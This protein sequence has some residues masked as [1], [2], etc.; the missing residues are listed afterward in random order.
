[1]ARNKRIGRL[2]VIT[3]TVLQQRYPAH[4]LA[5]LAIQGGADTIQ[6][7]SKS[8]DFRAMFAEASL[9]REVC[10]RTGVLFIVNDRVDLC[11]AVDADGVHLGSNDMPVE[12]ARRI[13]G[14]NRI[15]GG[16][17]RDVEGLHVAELQGADYVG[18]GPI[19]A[20]KSKLVNHHP[21]GIAGIE[22]VVRAARIPI[23]AIAGITMEN[24]RS[25]VGAGAHGVAV[26]GAVCSAA[27]VVGATA[28]L[29][30]AMDASQ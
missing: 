13:I 6:Y 29:L 1:M 4:Q 5:E 20:T 17:V 30:D 12:V 14:S 8:L 9:V 28:S 16:T 2:H 25:I 19:F 26:I 18:L 15:I 3:D 22:S 23:I 10:A 11:E 27:D 24:I 21:I 7:R